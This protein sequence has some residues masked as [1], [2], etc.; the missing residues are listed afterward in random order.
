MFQFA[1][2]R[3]ERA[4]RLEDF[5]RGVNDRLLATKINLLSKRAVTKSAQS[6]DLAVVRSFGPHNQPKN[7][8][9][10]RAIAANQTNVFSGIDL[11]SDAAQHL[12]R[13]VGF[14]YFCETEKHTLRQ[15]DGETERRREREFLFSPSLC[16]S[17]PPSLRPSVSISSSAHR[18][19]FRSPR[20]LWPPARGA[21]RRSCSGFRAC[22][23]PGSFRSWPRRARAPESPR[24]PPACAE[25]GSC[26][27]SLFSRSDRPGRGRA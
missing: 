6:F 24:Q 4:Q 27:E 7:G 21:A 9:L 13:A 8:R 10:A 23:G 22:A 11:K 26:P 17:V 5:E 12:L 20:L 14:G 16:L 1:H 19:G 18:S 25:T 15:G 2:L 3:F